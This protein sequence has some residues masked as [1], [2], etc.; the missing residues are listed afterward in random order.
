MHDNCCSLKSHQVVD[1][2]A[3]AAALIVGDDGGGGISVLPETRGELIGTT[4]T[5]GKVVVHC[6]TVRW[7]TDK[8]THGA[9]RCGT[10]K[11][12]VFESAWDWLMFSTAKQ[13]K[14]NNFL[15]IRRWRLD[16][17]VRRRSDTYFQFFEFLVWCLSIDRS[18]G[19]DTTTFFTFILARM[20]FK[21]LVA[22]T[23]QQDWAFSFE[24]RSRV[25]LKRRENIFFF[26]RAEH[27]GPRK[28]N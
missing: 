12:L 9:V 20:L 2:A 13:S 10:D 3:A 25:S 24:Q 17:R 28:K 26:L 16:S 22:I 23:W 21:L 14:S 15:S 8:R 4:M 6:L 1:D 11:C 5:C 18:D 7:R 19:W 27:P